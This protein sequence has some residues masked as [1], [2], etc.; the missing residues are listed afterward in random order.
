MDK[1]LKSKESHR[2]ALIA[3]NEYRKRQ[4]K[5]KTNYN[6]LIAFY[7]KKGYNNL[8]EQ[9]LTNAIQKKIKSD[10]PVIYYKLLTKIKNRKR[11]WK[12]AQTVHKTIKQKNIIQ[13]SDT[14]EDK[15]NKKVID[16][17]ELIQRKYL[18]SYHIGIVSDNYNYK[19]REG[20]GIWDTF[21]DE[22][23]TSYHEL[24]KHS[25]KLKIRVQ[26]LYDKLRTNDNY[27]NYLLDSYLQRC[28][29]FQCAEVEDNKT[30]K[31]KIDIFDFRE[32]TEN[33]I[34][35]EK[36]KKLGLNYL[37]C[38][39][40]QYNDNYCVIHYLADQMENKDKFKHNDLNSIKSQF[41]SM[42]INV[43][44]GI[45]LIQ[46]Q[47]YINTFQEGKISYY[48]YDV[49]YRNI[50]YKI[51]TSHN[52]LSLA[53]IIANHHLYP[54]K[55]DQIKSMISKTKKIELGNIK[56]N[57]N[58]NEESKLYYVDKDNTEEIQKLIN[59]TISKEYQ[60]IVTNYPL[61]DIVYKIVM[62]SN[63][64][65]YFNI[66]RT[67]INSI[68]HPVTGQIYEYNPNYDLTKR[69]CD[70]CNEIY[71]LTHNFIFINQS[72]G[73]IVTE[74]F[75]IVEGIIKPYQQTK[76]DFDIIDKYN[77]NAQIQTIIKDYKYD[78]QINT[79]IDRRCAYPNTILKR[80]EDDDIPLF[81][82]TDNFDMFYE[83]D[84]L[85]QGEYLIRSFKTKHDLIFKS[86]IWNY[87]TV[88]E[89]LKRG[90]IQKS[91]II[92]KRYT[93]KTLSIK[94]IQHFAN[95]VFKLFPLDIAKNCLRILIGKWG[96]RYN[97]KE[98]GCVCNDIDTINALYLQYFDGDKNNHLSHSVIED[99]QFFRF[100]EK[101]PEYSNN[102]SIWRYVIN[103]SNLDLLE[104]I[105]KFTDEYS[106]LV[107]VN[108]DSVYLENAI[109]V[110]KDIFDGSNKYYKIEKWNPKAYKEIITNDNYDDIQF[111]KKNEWNIMDNNTDIEK[112]K[113]SSF[114]CTGCPGSGK[115][116]LLSEIVQDNKTTL[117]LSL[118]NVSVDN[119]RK[120]INNE[121]IRVATLDSYFKFR[122]II[123]NSVDR[124]CI[125][126]YTMMS[127]KFYEYLYNSKIKNP[128]LIIQ[129][130]GD[131]NQCSSIENDGIFRIYEDTNIIKFLC[132]S[133][134]IDKKYN[135]ET[136]RYD[137]EIRDILEYLLIN[138]KLPSYLIDKKY[139]VNPEIEFNIC[140]TN[141]KVNKINNKFSK[142]NNHKITRVISEKNFYKDRVYNSRIYK[143]NKFVNDKVELLNENNE[144]IPR[145]FKKSDFSAVY[146]ICSY[147]C[148]S[149]TI[150]EDINILE[151]KI[152]SLQEIYTAISRLRQ[153]NNLHI[154][155]TN[156]TFYNKKETITNIKTENYDEGSVYLSTNEKCKK[157]Y[158]GQTIQQIE[159]R[160]RQHL[161]EPK[162]NKRQTQ[163][164]KYPGKWNIQ[165]IQK[166][167]YN[168]SKKLDKLEAYYINKYKNMYQQDLINVKIPKIRNK[169]PIIHMGIFDKNINEYKPNNKCIVSLKN[170]SIQYIKDKSYYI[171]RIRR[172]NENHQKMML[173]NENNEEQVKKAIQNYANNYIMNNIDSQ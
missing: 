152:M 117:V 173:F 147:R 56:Y 77:P 85:K 47:N 66:N 35:K 150:D 114:L 75:K 133:N 162:E 45:N 158:I 142:K 111:F 17:P 102:S 84:E 163:L 137:T 54:I 8:S 94:T 12:K 164:H 73:C 107:G 144:I 131:I 119:I 68:M 138:H 27:E 63:C 33:N 104:M 153:I 88:L 58:L 125:D 40:D 166:I 93:N 6:K 16:D 157:Y 87:R 149:L 82:L 124:V 108:T 19:Q 4:G 70:R 110:T 30:L 105:D 89:L 91:D 38:S 50:S 128:N 81:S 26:E 25:A 126:E 61:R 103:W 96:R 72:I 127:N 3:Y 67:L 106:I 148:Q 86:Q 101:I 32:V 11:Q 161:Q 136:S 122:T 130:F 39:N 129:M 97:N 80:N 156:V 24:D 118:T 20:V 46:F 14:D 29:D 169:K 151:T 31:V 37:G 109:N 69:F 116:T 15:K 60:L 155:Y 36:M 55:E 159:Q 146:G 83:N 90:L 28:D 76:E 34:K 115:S 65:P 132:N 134:K 44:K 62:D 113:N 22:I 64:V 52:P 135:P 172:K 168:D 53:F 92:L 57:K 120:M 41:E 43:D 74:L 143:V 165:T 48:A 139:N 99:L 2:L 154:K 95:F 123:S 78:E 121:K 59:G 13:L 23:I 160:L 21:K 7:G 167:Y 71:P 141:N 170:I 171:F 98:S 145:Y 42:N 18:V 51:A 9:R 79:A 112:L 10:D 100:T 5:K 1:L 49:L 140:K